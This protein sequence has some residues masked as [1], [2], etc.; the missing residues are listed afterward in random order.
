MEIQEAARLG[1]TAAVEKVDFGAIMAHMR[2]YV[3]DIL[4]G[5]TKRITQNEDYDFYDG[6]GRFTGDHIIEVNGEQLHAERIAIAC[7]S[8]PMV[9]PIPGLDTVDYITNEGA[10]KLTECPESLIIITAATWRWN[11]ATS[12]P[13]WVPAS[14]SSR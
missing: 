10:L 2:W 9:P 11:S 5:A 12:S 13:P 3:Q 1:I 6:Q 8:R 14:P 7:G 4:D